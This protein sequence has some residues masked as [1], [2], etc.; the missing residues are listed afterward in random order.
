MGL[1]KRQRNAAGGRPHTKEI[2]LTDEQLALLTMKAAQQQMTIQRLLVAAVLEP[3][4]VGL[5]TG[6]LT[7]ADK[8]EMLAATSELQRQ[9]SAIGNN[10]NQIAHQANIAGGVDPELRERH[11]DALDQLRELWRAQ[12]ATA[13]TMRPGQ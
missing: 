3:G 5:G 9:L 8:V 12:S 6:G 4:T 2:T 13:R 7:H 10:I 1:R 11:I